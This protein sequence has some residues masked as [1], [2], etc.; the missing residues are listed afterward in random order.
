MASGGSLRPPT[1]VG[2][3]GGEQNSC[4]RC[5]A[6]PGLTGTVSVDPQ[7]LGN[8]PLDTLC[9]AVLPSQPLS[10]GRASFVFDLPAVSAVHTCTAGHLAVPASGSHL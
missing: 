5:T 9:W 7:S 4:A 6:S 1:R 10:K 3:S 2:L 8:E